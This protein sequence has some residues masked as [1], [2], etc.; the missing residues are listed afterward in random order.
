MLAGLSL[1]ACKGRSDE[2]KPDAAVYS[3]PLVQGYSDRCA[4]SDWEACRLLGIAYTE[5]AKEAN[6]PTS[7]AKA[8]V[9]F[10][11]ACDGGLAAACNNLGLLVAEGLGG[12]RDGPRGQSLFRRACDGGSLL[13]CRNLGLM[14]ADGRGVPVD[15]LG[16]TIAFGKACNGGL[17]FACTNLGMLAAKLRQ[18]AAAPPNA[19][20]PAATVAV[21]LWQ[22]GCEGGDP[23]G[24]R[25]LG[26]A[27]LQGFGV[28]RGNAPASVWLKRACDGGDGRGCREL[29]DLA[30]RRGA[31][32][33]AA[34]FMAKAC[35]GG[36]VQA[37]EPQPAT[38]AVPTPKPTAP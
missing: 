23:A 14:L 37:C 24:C 2:V 15:S 7:P 38:S 34:E 8:S 11:K 33:E 18:A 22:R 29:A 9:L 13:G 28:P 17:G 12:E 5:G 19:N 30:K 36:E 3:N 1:A 35:R 26:I 6:L 32:D 31:L 27:Y 4:A 10:G 16:A 21:A 20:V 25:A